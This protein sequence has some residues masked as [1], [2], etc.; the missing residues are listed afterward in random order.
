VPG[1][2]AVEALVAASV[3]AGLSEL[4]KLGHV[5]AQAHSGRP[6]TVV[7]DLAVHSVVALVTGRVSARLALSAHFWCSHAELGRVLACAEVQF[8]RAGLSRWEKALVV[9]GQVAVVARR[10]WGLVTGAVLLTG[11]FDGL[12]GG[13]EHAHALAAR[14]VGLDLV[15]RLAVAVARRPSGVA[16]LAN[17]AGVAPAEL[18]PS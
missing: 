1:D 6:G 3:V 4:T 18:G 17:F 10:K 12:D 7:R 2:F 14:V 5:L 8:T 11:R 15:A 16:F 13:H 9:R